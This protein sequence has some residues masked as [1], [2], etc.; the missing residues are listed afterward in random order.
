MTNDLRKTARTKLDAL[1]A[2]MPAMGPT[3]ATVYAEIALPATTPERLATI[4]SAV[5]VLLGDA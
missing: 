1:T 5:D 4:A 2:K 3:F